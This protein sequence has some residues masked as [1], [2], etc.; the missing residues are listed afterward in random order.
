MTGPLGAVFTAAGSSLFSS[1]VAPVLAG[2]ELLGRLLEL[3]DVFSE[4]PDFAPL[5]GF[6]LAAF[7]A[8]ST[9]WPLAQKFTTT[10]KP[11]TMIRVR[12]P[13][14]WTEVDNPRITAGLPIGKDSLR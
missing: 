9:S 12:M 1:L 7:S 14:T 8:E 10:A 11:K 13:D 6:F 2:A 5:A 3:E 4:T